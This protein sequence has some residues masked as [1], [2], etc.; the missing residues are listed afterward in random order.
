MGTVRTII[1]LSAV[2]A[3][4]ASSTGCAGGGFWKK[5][6]E[7]K[8]P[9]MNAPMAGSSAVVKPDGGVIQAGG[10]SPLAQIPSSL[11]R[12]TGKSEKGKSGAAVIAVAWRNHIDFLPDPNRQGAMSPGLAG[13]VFLF[14]SHDQPAFADGTITVDLYDET[15]RPAGQEPA[16]PER[17][18]FKKDVLATLRTIDERFGPNYTLFLPWPTYRPG[19]TRVRI[20]VRYDPE[21]GG[22]PLYAPES[23]MALDANPA[24]TGSLK[25]TGTPPG[26]LPEMNSTPAASGT[27]GARSGPGMGVIQMGGR[28]RVDT[29]PAR[30]D[31]MPMPPTIG[32][33]SPHRQP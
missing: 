16:R 22:Y 31:Q 13:Q 33:I 2:A 11:A 7:W 30:T 21:K 4:V 5:K 27:T 14:G 23:K 9:E 19:I 25:G 28:P 29:V 3:G 26:Q 20:T 17:W 18:Q 10:I 8:V 6:D 1:A 15:V 32:T 12:M 24:S